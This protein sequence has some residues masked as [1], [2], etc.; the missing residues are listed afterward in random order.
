M[1]LAAKEYTRAVERFGDAPDAHCGLA[2]AFYHS[3][4]QVMIQA[5]DAAL[6]VN[7]RQPRH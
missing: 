7:P 6:V 4:R 2:Q 3:D 1:A 5:L